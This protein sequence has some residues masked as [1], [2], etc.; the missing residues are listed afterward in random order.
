M[1]A[2]TKR[3]DLA[4]HVSKTE[5]ESNVA[6]LVLMQENAFGFVQQTIFFVRVNRVD[7][8][9]TKETVYRETQSSGQIV[10]SSFLSERG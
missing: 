4:I 7:N 10:I 3:G 1:P 2:A 9:V 6:R 5:K 8:Q